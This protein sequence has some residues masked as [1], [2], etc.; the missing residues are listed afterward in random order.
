MKT[1][2][3]IDLITSVV[4]YT[5]TAG[6]LVKSWWDKKLENAR[7]DIL[8]EIRAGVFDNVDIDD[9]ISIIHRLLRAISE[10]TA[11]KNFRLICRLVQG[12]SDCKKLTAP[13]FLRFASV[14]DSLT[15]DEIKVISIDLYDDYNPKPI[16]NE[17]KVEWQKTK[18]EFIIS[19]GFEPRNKHRSYYTSLE[20]NDKITK[21]HYALLR[22]GLYSL[23]VETEYEDVVYDKEGPRGPYTN[24]YTEF[25]TTDLMTDLKDVVSFY[26]SR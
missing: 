21:V 16:D 22:T 7:E 5:S 14:L 3:V 17:K 19:L 24:T 25:V 13:I 23:V 10:G 15:E 18:D 9:Q 11:R 8:A 4:P 26:I 1:N 20:D 12:L 2:T 6:T